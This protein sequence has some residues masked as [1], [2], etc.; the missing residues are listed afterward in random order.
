MLSLPDEDSTAHRQVLRRHRV[1]DD[2]VR[3]PREALL[4][5]AEA[6]RL[7]N[8]PRELGECRTLELTFRLGL[9]EGPPYFLAQIFN[10]N[11]YRST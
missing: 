2:D 10:R 11:D 6:V 5:D 3:S 9:V 4:D 8:L 1:A 7:E